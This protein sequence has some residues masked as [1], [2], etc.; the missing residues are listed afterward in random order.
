MWRVREVIAMTNFEA[1]AEREKGLAGRG[2]VVGGVG[3]WERWWMCRVESQEAETRREW[4]A[5]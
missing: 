1:E 5:E 2:I 4:G 3:G